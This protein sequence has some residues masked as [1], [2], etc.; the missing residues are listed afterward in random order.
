[1][2][3]VE[4][5]R[6][7]LRSRLKPLDGE[8]APA[9]LLWTDAEGQ[10]RPLLDPLCATLPELF[11]L[12]SDFVPEKRTG[13]AI[14]LKCIVDRALP[15]S[16]AL[17]N[18]P[19]LYLPGVQRPLDAACPP[20][21]QPLVELQFRGAVWTRHGRD[22]G[23][24][25]F[26]RS[27]EGLGLDV[28]RDAATEA[29][30]CRCL[31]TLAVLSRSEVVGLLG[32][33]LHA[34]DFDLLQTP[35]PN[36]EFLRW[37]NDP[38][39]A[40]T[41]RSR[42]VWESLR[43]A[44]KRRFHFDPEADDP[45]QA[46][47]SLRSGGTPWDSLWERFAESP[48]LY[49]G[50]TKLMAR[51]LDPRPSVR[52]Q[53]LLAFAEERNPEFNR[54][55]EAE[56]RE[57]IEAGAGLPQR[58]AAAQILELENSHGVRRQWAWSRM[59]HSPWAN[60][61]LPL[62]ELARR[63]VEAMTG[64]DVRTL[65]AAYAAH[66]WRSDQAALDAM[67]AFRHG[68]DREI[69]A[70]ATRTIYAPWLDASAYLF[71]TAMSREQITAAALAEHA[72]GEKGVCIVFVDGLRF[73]LGMRLASLLGRKAMLVEHSHRVAPVPTV[74]ATAKP[75]AAPI[76]V[77][78]S[79]SGYA[80]FVPS[81]GSVAF[82]APVLRKTLQDAGVRILDRDGQGTGLS[83]DGA[84]SGGW[85]ECGRI[86][87]VGHA[88][89]GD[90]VNHCEQELERIAERI[91][92][93][94]ES[95]WKR[96]RV[97]TDHGWLLMQ[98]GLPKVELPK[99][100]ATTRWSRCAIPAG[101]TGLPTYPWY[102]DPSVRVTCAPGI[103]CFVAGQEYA[104]GGVSLQECVV[105]ELL[106]EPEVAS[107]HAVIR[108]IIWRGMRCRVEVANLSGQVRADIREKWNDGSTT[109]AT[110]P[111]VIGPSGEVSLLVGKDE[112]MHRAASVVLLDAKGKILAHETTVVAGPAKR[113]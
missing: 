36:R 73:D 45:A 29:A 65:A 40:S 110:G 47:A 26:L 30:I 20:Q 103:G 55:Q 19:I 113:L 49:P 41:L 50:L 80:D 16:A 91:H 58:E 106:V 52:A 10:W 100:M 44:W 69:M 82:T 66:G 90:L 89:Q 9:V 99:Y 39:I 95:G 60:A 8:A 2:V 27:D 38:E 21:L 87:E 3:L 46:A 111:K 11:A 83:P 18:A 93:V 64:T 7:S 94:L 28:A 42:E 24:T 96:V 1:M 88:L 98:G 43:S 4:R 31:S 74:T 76:Q 48:R 72:V 81:V 112:C 23:V 84:S 92:A 33:R 34:D 86:D 77:K 107:A 97:V 70:A 75:I 71:Q 37:L 61:L 104:H 6:E 79:G 54:Q 14:W 109:M 56:L 22:W 62:A 17:P 32:R 35:D 57:R 105:P 68:Q 108:E 12:G 25:E 13:P 63:T 101:D 85:L 78:L 59:G 51:P 102:W 67:A 15:E 5:L 53:G